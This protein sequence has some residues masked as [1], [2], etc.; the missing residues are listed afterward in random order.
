MTSL[1]NIR[2]A[3]KCAFCKFWYDPANSN[4]APKTPTMGI[5]QVNDTNKKSTCLK[6]NLQ[7]PAYSFCPKYECKL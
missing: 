7:V 1:Y 2:S 3:K 4:I 5:W 6:K